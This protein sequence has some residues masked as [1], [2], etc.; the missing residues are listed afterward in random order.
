M[1]NS[2]SATAVEAVAILQARVV[3]ARPGSDEEQITEKAIDYC[4]ARPDADGD[5]EALAAGCQRN[6]KYAFYR[7]E[8]RRRGAIR[9]YSRRTYGKPVVVDGA[10]DL[11]EPGSLEDQVI[12]KAS[13]LCRYAVDET[14][15]FAEKGQVFIGR[16]LVGDTVAE[17]AQQVGISRSTGYR[18]CGV[19]ATLL[20]PHR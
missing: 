8:R 14:A 12:E 9:R 13:E 17:A 6:A 2:L 1:G 19:L 4:L 20:A 11:I 5:P 3:R 10:V 15:E 16:L 18:W 7:S